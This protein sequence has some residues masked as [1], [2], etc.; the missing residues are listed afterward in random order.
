MDLLRTSGY[1][2]RLVGAADDPASDAC[3]MLIV[4]TRVDDVA[5]T[6]WQNQTS[7]LEPGAVRPKK[8]HVFSQLVEDFKPRMK[9]QIVE[10]LRK[11]GDSSN[12]SVKF[13]REQ[14]RASIIDTLEIHP[15]SAPELRKLLLDDEEDRPFLTSEE[16][17]GIPQLQASLAGLAQK[18]KEQKKLLIDDIAQ[19]LSTTLIS[20]IHLIEAQ[21]NQEDREQN[22][23]KKL[24]E[25]LKPILVSQK[26]E[27]R[28]RAAAFRNFLDETVQ[29]KIEALVLEARDV[30]EED[31]R[32]Y[33]NS[34]RGAHW[35]TL[36]A[37]V[38]RGG[39]FYGSRNINFPDDIT[40]YFME[41]MAAVWG[42]K[43]LR[44]IRL[45]TTKF[46]SDTVE[47][48]QELCEW[49]YANGGDLIN[50]ELLQA[51]QD[52]IAALAKQMSS[53]GK[54]ASDEL[55]QTVKSELSTAIRSP[56]KSACDEF[57][58]DGDDIGPGVKLRILELFARLAKVAT[59]AA[60]DPAIRI[61]KENAYR[62]RIE[63]QEELR[64][65]GD[66]LQETAD[67]IVETNES[68]ILRSDAQKRALILAE[69]SV[70]LGSFS[71]NLFS[72]PSDK[73]AA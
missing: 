55:R 31:V 24:E 11:I 46:A 53:V 65:G 72:Q 32:E 44:D 64:K 39:T 36:R 45:K 22:E 28:A 62:V 69:V 58:S 12:E 27:Y 17:T 15:V 49:A 8:R 7:D 35:A 3:S 66:P 40:G 56:I 67:L 37:A 43:L 20:E 63:V 68:R 1:W 57:V 23:A 5:Q 6:E 16:Q 60:K 4:V 26:E 30:A 25:S 59:S 54:E 18:E 13:A 61:L 21:W 29:A 10:Q 51:Q 70:V 2:E 38:R 50:K 52:R 71:G 47:M 73:V 19:R 48:V 14:A 41:P 42:Q 34:L 33:F 9:A